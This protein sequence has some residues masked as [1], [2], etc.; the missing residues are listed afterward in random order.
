L[1][2]QSRS[3]TGRPGHHL[4]VLHKLYI[5]GYHIRVQSS[6]RFERDAGRN[7]E[8]MLRANR[9]AADQE[10]RKTEA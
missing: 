4:S 3:S 6:R 9:P 7:V 10:Y 1:G 8:M 5:H 2:T